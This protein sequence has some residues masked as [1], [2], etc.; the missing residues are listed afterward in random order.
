MF[1]NH[2][3]TVRRRLVNHDDRAQVSHSDTVV[4]GMQD[5]LRAAAEQAG[6]RGFLSLTNGRTLTFADVERRVR[7]LVGDLTSFGVRSGDRVVVIPDNDPES[8]ARL[9][10]IPRT[11]AAAV[12][13]NSRLKDAEVTEQVARV[14]ATAGFDGVGGLEPIP[15]SG[16]VDDRVIAV[17]TAAHT[18]M[19]TS[20][21][22][23]RPKPVI[24]TWG[25]L[26]ASAAASARHL[27]HTSDDRWYCGLPLSHIAGVSILTRS[28]RERSM[29][30]LE[31]EFDPHRA[32]QLLRDGSVTLGSV[33]PSML[34]RILDTDPGP[35]RGVRALLV[36]G[37]AVNTSLL[38]EAAEAGL[39]V[40][41]TYGMTE[42]ASQIATRPLAD[43]LHPGLGA[44]PLS[45][46]EIRI[47]QDGRVELRGPMV[48]PGYLGEPQRSAD[49]WF[50]TSDLGTIDRGTLL[51]TGRAD[52]VLITG[53]ENVHPTEVENVIRALPGVVDVAVV[54]LSHPIWGQQV[55][56]V[57]EGE[58][59]RGALERHARY[60]LAGFKVP[61]RW[62]TVDSLPRL[63]IGKLD[64]RAVLAYAESQLD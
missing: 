4:A 57:V 13:I 40:L 47:A 20:G 53:G 42:T 21:S 35:Y 16:V 39:P 38:M 26:D 44:V 1:G 14:D 37:G 8:V 55:V 64:R 25:N 6:D 54:G 34:R 51:V 10:A 56:A 46:A 31:T 43:G 7:E 50:T 15:R 23:G 5:W 62:L 36:G 60:H 27:E 52:D 22:S 12:V 45:G 58:V 19:F 30:A 61:K 18:I 17:P 28:A 9:F 24:L 49:T 63:S 48:S 11:G 33:V 41:P 2:G 59:G 29:V 3:A 32:A